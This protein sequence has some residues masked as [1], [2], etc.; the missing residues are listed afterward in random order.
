VIVEKRDERRIVEPPPI[1]RIVQQTPHASRDIE[2][3]PLRA[4]EGRVA[5]N[6]VDL[7]IQPM[8]VATMRGRRATRRQVVKVIVR[9]ETARRVL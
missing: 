4:A 3:Q 2:D 7:P 1:G 5:L 6:L 8:S 9:I